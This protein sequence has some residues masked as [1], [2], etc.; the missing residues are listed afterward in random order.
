L[1]TLAYVGNNITFDLTDKWFQRCETDSSDSDYAS[2]VGFLNIVMQG[3]SVL[4]LQLNTTIFHFI[5]Q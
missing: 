3:F 2:M 4:Y 5:G 1:D